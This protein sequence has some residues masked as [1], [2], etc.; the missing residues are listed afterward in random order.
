MGG[1]PLAH[2]QDRHRSQIARHS[3]VDRQPSRCPPVQTLPRERPPPPAPS[4][5]TTGLGREV[6]IGTPRSP[7]PNLPQTNYQ[8]QTARKSQSRHTE[9]T[10]SHPGDSPVLRPLPSI[11]SGGPWPPS[12]PSASSTSLPAPSS[13]PS[14]DSVLR[15]DNDHLPYPR[16]AEEGQDRSRRPFVI[17][18][19]GHPGNSGVFPPAAL[20]HGLPELSDLM[21]AGPAIHKVMVAG[22]P[23]VLAASPAPI[24]RQLVNLVTQVVTHRC[25][26]RQGADSS[27]PRG[28]CVHGG[29]PFEASAACSA[30]GGRR[31]PLSTSYP[32]RPC[33]SGH[34]GHLAKLV[35]RR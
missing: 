19:Q 22:L 11:C 28:P 31:G 30:V 24:G 16:F 8:K 1:L 6:Q 2:D 10:L 17:R 26:P 15:G 20:A 25:V 35:S 9:A 4:R 34:S 7:L 12:S 3:R 33:L 32:R 21:P 23:L 27:G 5:R 14:L 13:S 29:T 18:K